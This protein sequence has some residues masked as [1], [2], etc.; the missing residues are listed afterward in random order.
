MFDT[1]EINILK[2]M[3]LDLLRVIRGAGPHNE[4]HILNVLILRASHHISFGFI[5]ISAGSELS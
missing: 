1:S 4:H 5:F 2:I 3:A